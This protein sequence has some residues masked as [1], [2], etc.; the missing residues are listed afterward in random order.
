MSDSIIIDD[1]DLR[2]FLAGYPER[3]RFAVKKGFAKFGLFF[4][5][6]LVKK[7]LSGG[8]GLKRRTG[9]LAKSFS[10]VVVETA[11]VIELRIASYL[12]YARIHEKGGV[13][14]PVNS[15]YLAIP[16]GDSL[17]PAGVSKKGSPLDDP[18]LLFMC[19]KGG[20]PFLGRPIG[21]GQ[22]QVFFLLRKSVTIPAR[23][24][25]E[26][27]FVDAIKT[28]KYVGFIKEAFAETTKGQ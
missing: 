7:S 3:A 9:Y 19:K 24:K 11:D 23:L 20:K 16:V 14:K 28:R 27:A 13:I 2:K 17:T 5:A 18:T 6:L 25:L 15:K 1:S 8:E 12:P 21:N 10:H 26:D 22:V 4:N